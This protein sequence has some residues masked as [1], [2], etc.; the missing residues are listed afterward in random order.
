MRTRSREGRSEAVP[1][2][3][4]GGAWKPEAQREGTSSQPSYHGGAG[5][6]QEQRAT[7]ARRRL[8]SG[9]WARSAR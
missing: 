8:V 5:E 4:A 7:P 2:R 9:E 1:E 6:R 3:E